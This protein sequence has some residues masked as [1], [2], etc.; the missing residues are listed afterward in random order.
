VKQK[1]KDVLTKL[2]KAK[3]VIALECKLIEEGVTKYV[4]EQQV[5]KLYKATDSGKKLKLTY[6]ENYIR[7]IPSDIIKLKNT[8]DEMM[9]FDN[10]CILHYDPF[11]NSTDLTEKEKTEKKKDPIMFGVI[12]DSRKLYFI[13]DWTDEYCDLTLDKMME[14]I[15]EKELDVNNESVISYIEKI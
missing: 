2:L 4:T 11:N 9:I 8:A 14:I 7:V 12:K 5:V 10:Y 15:S 13:G 3:E 1:T 6:L